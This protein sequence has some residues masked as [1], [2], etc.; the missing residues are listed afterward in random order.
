VGDPRGEGDTLE[1]ED[2][3][4]DD[5]GIPGKDVAQTTLPPSRGIRDILPPPVQSGVVEAR[6]IAVSGAAVKDRF[7]RNRR[8][9]TTGF[10]LDLSPR[11]TVQASRTS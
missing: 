7:N 6:V 2:A 11:A 1:A 10:R 5:N 4:P 8:G 9:G 3:E